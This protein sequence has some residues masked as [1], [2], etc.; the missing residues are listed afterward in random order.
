[1]CYCYPPQSHAQMVTPWQ[2][3]RFCSQIHLDSLNEKQCQEWLHN[4]LS[5]CRTIK[6]KEK[7]KTWL[8]YI[9]C[10]NWEELACLTYTPRTKRRIQQ[11]YVDEKNRLKRIE[12]SKRR[13]RILEE[14]RKE[15]RLVPYKSKVQSMSNQTTAS[16][17]EL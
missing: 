13:K 6:D 16:I 12:N 9:L 17:E 8:C 15:L 7:Q 3:L 2:S 1:M 11:M 5:K 10:G 14:T 4:A